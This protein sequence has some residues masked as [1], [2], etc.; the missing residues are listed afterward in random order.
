MEMTS[1]DV[2]TMASCCEN[3]GTDATAISRPLTLL[4]KKL[5]ARFAIDFNRGFT[6]FSPRRQTA[7]NSPFIPMHFALRS[8]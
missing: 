4:G 7:V 5:A 8:F 1:T 3:N 2:G 6:F